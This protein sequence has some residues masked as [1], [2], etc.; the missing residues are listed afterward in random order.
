MKSWNRT[1]SYHRVQDGGAEGGDLLLLLL[2]DVRS[3]FFFFFLCTAKS[4]MD[5]FISCASKVKANQC[6]EL[7]IV[8]II[9]FRPPHVNQN[10]PTNPNPTKSHPNHKLY[11]PIL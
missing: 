2:V 1:K 7:F 5:V 3:L 11:M 8:L 9:S 4:M 10:N 6:L